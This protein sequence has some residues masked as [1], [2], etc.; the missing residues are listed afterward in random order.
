MLT[1]NPGFGVAQRT[2][3]PEAENDTAAVPPVNPNVC[4]VAAD[5]GGLLVG[6]A[7]VDWVVE[8]VACCV[9]VVVDVVVG[10]ND[11]P[12]DELGNDA[13]DR[14]VESVTV[15]VVVGEAGVAG[16]AKL[17]SS[18][19]PGSSA[20]EVEPSAPTPPSSL[21]VVV[22]DL[23]SDAAAASAMPAAAAGAAESK[24]DGGAMI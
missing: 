14:G 10:G 5:G 11:W 19:F 17:R 20:A 1:S 2:S 4:V 7:V 18:P 15:L 13:E 3:T 22:V 16:D 9:V 23:P 12:P 21:T 6:V 8:V 24:A